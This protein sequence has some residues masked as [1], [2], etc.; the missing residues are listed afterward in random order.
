MKIL[1]LNYEYPPIGGGAANAN[2]YLLKEFSKKTIHVD[3]VTSSPGKYKEE[4]FSKNIRIFR[5]NVGKK[6][7]H[8]WKA[9]EAL[10][11]TTK[12]LFFSKKLIKKHN[13]DLIHSFF[14]LPTGMIPYILNKPYIVSLRGSDVPGFNS[15]LSKLENMQKPIFNNICKK[16]RKVI[17]NSAG[18]KQ[19]AEKSYSGKIDII[20][21][22]IDTAEFSSSQKKEKLIICVSR[23]IERKGI[24]YLIEAMP[25]I[26]KE[27]KLVIIGDGP[28]KDELIRL[29][30]SNNSFSRIIFL[31]YIKHDKLPTYYKKSMMFVL[32]SLNEGMSNTVL[33]AMSSGLPI[34]T[35][36]T[37][38]TNEL[39]RQNG[40][41]IEKE[42]STSIANAVNTL[43]E[44]DK[45][46]EELSR[47]SR[48]L[49]KTKSWK[50]TA[51][52]YLKT[53]NE[54]RKENLLK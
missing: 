5:L 47:N 9:S 22:G 25:K 35:T 19:L 30:K 18:L 12:A 53:Y 15:R 52:E 24:N 27:Y 49:A 34:V 45:L 3:L 26:N 17:A 33:E 54:A 13:Y 20:E 50:T 36:N 40:L 1:M 14:A 4:K 51:A 38:G 8:Y 37:G 39:I 28:K 46:R 43:I 31:D 42:S 2:Y 6:D 29:A 48:E 10:L 23:L 44:N 7:I 21:N 16:S 41:V 32:P 11:Y